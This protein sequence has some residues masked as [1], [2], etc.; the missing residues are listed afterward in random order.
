MKLPVRLPSGG[1]AAAMG[2]A[3]QALWCLAGGGAPG[4]SAVIGDLVDEHVVLEGAVV[5][6]D[7]K[8]AEAYDRAYDVYSQYLK[9]LSPLYI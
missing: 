4:T 5:E 9:A 8:A 1:E 2:G 6:P 3:I 7:A